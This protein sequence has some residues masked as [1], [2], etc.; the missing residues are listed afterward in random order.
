M[1]SRTKDQIIE[2]IKKNQH[3][4]VKDLVQC[5]GITQ[6]AVHRALNKLIEK[7]LIQKKGTPPRVF[8]F[9]A[10]NKPDLK[11]FE[12]TDETVKTLEKNYLYI[13]P[14]GKIKTGI[15]GFL[16][17]MI[18]TK[19]KQKLENCVL[20]YLQVLTESTSH[21][22]QSGLIDATKR[23]SQIFNNLNL[24][25]VY[26]KDFYSLIKF[27]KTRLGQLILHGKQAQDKKVIAQISKEILPSINKL[28]QEEKIEAI[29]WVPH[30]LPR[31]LPF[32]KEVKR[33][34][35][36]QLSEIEIVKSYQGEIPVA[37][38]SLSKIEE[39]VQ[40]AKETMVVVPLK[41]SYSKVLLIDDAVGSGSTLNEVAAKLKQKGVKKVIGFAIVGSYKGFEVIKEI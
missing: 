24:D 39:R 10:S 29:A 30:S 6:A 17:W 13:D 20:D 31:K 23:F 25:A 22:N 35:N 3:V 36:L 9:L 33:N 7:G 14:T 8:Y 28:I 5:L 38:K 11:S 19:N 21:K 2:I 15:E 12:L 18:A 32:L 41:I 34:L 40:N 4:Q 26:Y 37:Q 16:S 27:G 1:Y